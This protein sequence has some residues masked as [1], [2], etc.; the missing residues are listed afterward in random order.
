MYLVGVR[1]L[2]IH[3]HLWLRKV[4]KLGLGLGVW[5]QTRVDDAKGNPLTIIQIRICC[6]CFCVSQT[7]SLEMVSV[8]VSGLRR[9][10]TI[11]LPIVVFPK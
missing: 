7:G 10:L 9:Q 6:P 8:A 11:N 2:R 5:L 4:S 3:S 1:S